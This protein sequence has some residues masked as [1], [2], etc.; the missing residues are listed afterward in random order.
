MVIKEGDEMKVRQMDN[1]LFNPALSGL[2][3]AV[4][5]SFIPPMFTL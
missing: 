5:T 3:E 4:S 2:D 1:L